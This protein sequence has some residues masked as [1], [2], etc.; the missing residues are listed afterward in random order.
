M[1]TFIFMATVENN[2][3]EAILHSCKRSIKQMIET[4]RE[5]LRTLIAN[6]PEVLLDM[7]I[8][9]LITMEW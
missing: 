9:S 7:S 3:P 1:H 4:A 5:Y 2:L 6:E 8:V